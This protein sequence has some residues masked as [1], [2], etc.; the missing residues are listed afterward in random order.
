[1]PDRILYLEKTSFSLLYNCTL[2]GCE[3][4]GSQAVTHEG[5][6]Y[7]SEPQ[8]PTDKG[9]HE[10]FVYALRVGKYL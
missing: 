3:K 10:F 8:E 1:M 2:H 7:R 5:L 4:P 6:F 9:A